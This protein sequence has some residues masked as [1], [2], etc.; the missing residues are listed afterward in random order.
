MVGNRFSAPLRSGFL[1]SQCSASDCVWFATSFWSRH[2][3]ASERLEDGDFPGSARVSRAVFGVSLNTSWLALALWTPGSGASL[4]VEV[5]S[6]RKAARDAPPSDR[7]GRAP[8][9]LLR[10]ASFH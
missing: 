2:E 3:S 10:T 8:Q 5:S 1:Q 6:K 9:F 7:D 4:W